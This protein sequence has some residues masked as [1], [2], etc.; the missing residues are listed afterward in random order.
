M[1]KTYTLKIF[2][3]TLIKIYHSPINVY[4]YVPAVKNVLE[5][6]HKARFTSCR[7][8]D[9][10]TLTTEMKLTDRDGFSLHIPSNVLF[11]SQS[12]I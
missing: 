5:S 4:I 9:I 7:T 6:Q 2:F 10:G 1:L 11:T 8:C 12:I 3:R